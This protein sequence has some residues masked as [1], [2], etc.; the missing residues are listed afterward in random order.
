MPRLR[1][2]RDEALNQVA[3][4]AAS[5]DELA[6]QQGRWKATIARVSDIRRVTAAVALSFVDKAAFLAWQ[7]AS[8]DDLAQQRG[9]W[10]ATI[11]RVSADCHAATQ[12]H[13]HMLSSIGMQ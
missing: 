9:R 10:Q 5:R 13:L 12:P 4:L 6:R 11:A 3:R 8:C 7:A 2:E 1:G